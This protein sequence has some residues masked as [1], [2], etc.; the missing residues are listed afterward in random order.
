MLRHNLIFKLIVAFCCLLSFNACSEEPFS[1]ENKG[2]VTVGFRTD[3]NLKTKT[4]ID[5]ENGSFSWEI[6]DQIA[7]WAKNSSGNF[8]LQNQIFSLL[9]K[10][11]EVNAAY[12]ISE[13]SEA[14]PEGDYTYYVTSPVPSS[15]NGTYVDFNLSNNQNGFAGNG[16][17]ITISDPVS[18]GALAAVDDSNP[19]PEDP[20]NIKMKHLLHYLRFYIPEGCNTLMEDI[21]KIHFTMPQNICGTITA[22]LLDGSSSLSNG[23]NEMTLEL[24]DG[25][26]ENTFASAGIYPPA[27]TYGS[28]DAINITI[29]S[30]TKSAKLDPISLNGRSFKAG[31]ITSVP[32]RPGTPKNFYSLHFTLE[33]NNLGEDANA[34]ILTLPEGIYWPGT[35][36]NV[37]TYTEKDGSCFC[38]QEKFS[39]Y[40][41]L[42][43]EFLALSKQSVSVQYDSDNALVSETIT[44]PDLS[45]TVTANISLNCPYLFEQDFTNASTSFNKNG[46]LSSTGHDGATI[47]GSNYGLAGWTGNQVAV[48]ENSGNKALAIRH[49]N[50][51]YILQ[52][53]YRGRADSAPMSAIKSGKAIKVSVSF[54][55]TGYTNG[56]YIPQMTYGYTTDQSAL[57][58]YYEGG[59]SVI[60]GGTQ[61]SNAIESLVS[62]PTN[63]SVANVNLTK[64][65]Q[66][67]NCSNLHRLSWDCYGTK[68]SFS[69]TQE[70]IFIDNIKVRIVK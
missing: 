46:S 66:I 14:M 12:F 51:S 9:A 15:T 26:G 67:D 5:A 25:I 23:T 16:N 13:L 69:T 11:S 3:G 60:K 7:L 65:F 32:L 61:I 35:S 10:K 30:K 64:T 4:S 56:K 58:G 1:E 37:Y 53:T 27:T 42:E 54:N 20:M 8:V 6:N 43:S 52:G 24:K 45:S 29:Y 2:K 19:I 57:S 36:S 68:G 50:E 18:Y 59:S 49:Q 34:V 38:V 21:E 48:I 39:I 31:H 70:W 33:S 22:N 47:E 41:E 62:A 63:G 17:S 28:E 44:I 55:Y 40:T